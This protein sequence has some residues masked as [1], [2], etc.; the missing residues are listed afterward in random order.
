MKG[1][2]IAR[3]I[4]YSILI[5]VL[6]G[7]LFAVLG[8]SNYFT[9]NFGENHGT[10]V[11]GTL[12]LPASDVRNLEINW[13][14]GTITIIR[15]DVDEI[16]VRE[17]ANDEIKKPMTYDLS[18]NTLQLNYTEGTIRIGFGTGSIQ[19]KDLSIT[20]PMD[21]NCGDLAINSASTDV[22]IKDLSIDLLALNTASSDCKVSN[23]N[24]H[25]LELD[26]ASCDLNYSG[27]L[28]DLDCDGASTEIIAV[29]T[30]VPDSINM[31]GASADLDITLPADC[32]YEVDIDG[33]S[34]RCTSE[35]T[36]STGNHTYGNGA[37]KIV[38][39]GVSAKIEIHKGN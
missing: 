24:I 34:N 12:N 20:V 15:G 8:A 39:D 30:N 38:V 21:W 9:I 10:P 27:T 19:K 29:F 22:E 4:I 6:V 36:S 7:I 31:D 14:S 33:V 13:A 32:G 28:N 3:I 37:C 11:I 26:G 35:F 2:A 17:I 1:N 25:K 23:C 16:L 5:L 18:G